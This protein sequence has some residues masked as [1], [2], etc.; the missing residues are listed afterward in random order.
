M[1]RDTEN[2][3]TRPPEP[4]TTELAQ[5][6]RKVLD[7]AMELLESDK[8][9]IHLGGTGDKALSLAIGLGFPEGFTDPLGSADAGRAIWRLAFDRRRRVVVEDVTAEPIGAAAREI[10]ALHGVRSLQSAPLFA[11]DGQPF[12]LLSL[13]RA[14]PHRPSERELRLLE[15]FSRQAEQV[16]E[17]RRTFEALGRNEAG[18]RLALDAGAMGSWEWNIR[19]GEVR[20]SA[21]LERDPRDAPGHLRLHVRRLPGAHPPR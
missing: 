16:I 1:N 20:W 12:G 9:T 8:G 2:E 14:G 10:C 19:T 6:L 7:A 5:H 3:V 11:S 18:L 4:L 15:L 17:C 13:F 21:N